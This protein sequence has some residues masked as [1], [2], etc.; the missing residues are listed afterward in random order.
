[1]ETQQKIAALNPNTIN[2]HND[3]E[4]LYWTTHFDITKVKLK[5]AINAVGPE[6]KNI[7]AYL[8]KK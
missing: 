1:M 3:N 2:I 6:V 4:V 7:T 5:A 8:K